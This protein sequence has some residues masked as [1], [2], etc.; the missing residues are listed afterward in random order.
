MLKGK[1]FFSWELIPV[2]QTAAAACGSNAAA[3]ADV[4]ALLVT[5]NN[6]ADVE[7]TAAY[8]PTYTEVSALWQ[9]ADGVLAPFAGNAAVLS[10]VAGLVD[11]S[12]APPGPS[13]TGPVAVGAALA[14][15]V[16]L[17]YWWTKR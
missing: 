9:T 8:P 14:A 2:A 10:A 6:L 16:G 4:A 12:N 7:Q 11:D 15:A 3:C 1:Q 17:G 13:W 5:L